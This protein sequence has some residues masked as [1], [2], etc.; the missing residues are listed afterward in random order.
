MKQILL[1][2]LLLLGLS[3]TL[4]AQE[5]TKPLY[6]ALEMTDTQGHT[7][8]I[9]GTDNGLDIQE[10]KGKIVFLEFFGHQCP[11]C[12]A[13]IP[14]YIDL[15]KKYGDKIAILA[16]E[17]QGFSQKDLKAFGERKHITYSL[18]SERGANGLVQYIAQRAQWQGSIPFLVAMDTTGEVR[19]IQAGMLPESSLEKLIEMLSP[20]KTEAKGEDNSTQPTPKAVK[21]ETQEGNKTSK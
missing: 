4:L 16:I 13:S 20:K 2:T 9:K 7:Y 15:Q 1:S 14:H 12:L 3:Q 11:P 8:H 19:F 17:V 18:F 6:Q 5:P 10:L 21:Q